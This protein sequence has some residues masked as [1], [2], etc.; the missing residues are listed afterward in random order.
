LQ[1]EYL[2][3]AKTEIKV[4][5]KL[6]DE[7]AANY[8]N[9]AYDALFEKMRDLPD[10]PEK[11]AIIDDMVRL[12]QTDAPWMFGFN[13]MSGGAYQQWVGNAKPTQMVRN[14]LQYMKVDPA[15]RVKKIREWNQPVWW[16]IGLVILALL[17][18]ILPAWV[19]LRRQRMRT[20][21]A[22]DEGVKSP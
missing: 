16:P 4:G 22:I 2:L 19:A 14:T 6:T 9:P 11:A 13:P 12:L 20:A 10:G 8:E 17:V 1:R 15:L 21:I 18:L 7:N 3:F 5:D